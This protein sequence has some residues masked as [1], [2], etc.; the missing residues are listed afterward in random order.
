MARTDYTDD[1]NHRYDNLNVCLI[2]T[3]GCK[4]ALKRWIRKL[5]LNETGYYDSTALVLE[6]DHRKY[7]CTVR[8]NVFDYTYTF[9]EWKGMLT[10]NKVECKLIDIVKEQYKGS[11]FP[12]HARALNQIKKRWDST[13][14]VLCHV[15]A[16]KIA[17]PTVE[18]IIGKKI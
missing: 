18:D 5:F 3:S 9:D 1:S 17:K 6:W 15:F 11:K 14:A 10:A 13:E 16:L 8:N 12:F 7:I 4:A 2:R